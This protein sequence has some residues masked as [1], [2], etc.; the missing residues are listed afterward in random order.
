MPS[1]AVAGSGLSDCNLQALT[2]QHSEPETMNAY[3]RG[4]LIM[5]Y[6]SSQGGLHVTAREVC[7][8][9]MIPSHFLFRAGR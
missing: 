9:E 2:F 5:V 3:L 4:V 8:E 7:S 6:N 1:S